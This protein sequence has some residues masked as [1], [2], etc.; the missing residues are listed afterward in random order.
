MAGMQDLSREYLEE[1][2]RVAKQT[3][4]GWAYASIHQ[5][6]RA[7][8]GGRARHRGQPEPTLCSRCSVPMI[9]Q[10]KSSTRAEKQLEL[11][12]G[13]LATQ[14]SDRP[15]VLFVGA[16]PTPL[17]VARGEP[18]TGHAGT[19]FRDTY[20]RGLGLDRDQVAVTHLVPT[21]VTKGDPEPLE[22]T[23]WRPWLEAEIAR[24]RPAVVVAL[25]QVAKAALCDVAQ[26]VLPHP[27]AVALRFASGRKDPSAVKEV[28]RKLERIRKDLAALPLE[29][30]STAVAPETSAI[31]SPAEAPIQ[32]SQATSGPTDP[33]SGAAT[34]TEELGHQVKI[35]KADRKQQVVVGV[36]LD[37]Y[38]V[39]AHN[40][41]T[42]PKE[43]E[44]TAEA[45]LTKS[46]VIGFNHGG[47]ADAVPIQS[48]T[49]PYPSERDHDA[50][51]LEQPH[52]VS[53]IQ[54]G[55]QK[56]HSGAWLLK[57]KVNDPKTWAAIQKGEITGY[58]IGGF[59]TRTKVN[60]EAMPKVEFVDG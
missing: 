46:R 40:D 20:L 41:W 28:T 23:R 15:R 55:N 58:S 42:P 53:R 56:V 49:V 10:D 18:L 6:A 25:G 31:S 52:K 45:W 35:A 38:I 48:Y 34:V 36:V 9:E 47:K 3:L 24:L 5:E 21:P 22:V 33:G 12:A 4:P 17:D 32:R 2:L 26:H 39:D 1:A 44:A 60:R 57:V 59:S 43:I 19:L 13:A 27:R 7:A 14:G 16:A 37:P 29:D 30:L 8:S 50:A 11:P 51:M 54:I